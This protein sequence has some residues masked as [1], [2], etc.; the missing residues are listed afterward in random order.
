MTAVDDLKVGMFVAIVGDYEPKGW[1]EPEMSPFFSMCY[2]EPTKP[3][4]RA[5][6]QPLQIVAISLPFLA[7]TDGEKKYPIDVR[8]C[9]LQRLSPAYVR[10][11]M[12]QK[13]TKKA[14]NT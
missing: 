2:G 12:E 5:T 10:A 3:K 13:A 4:P 14:R 11:M 1:R 7:V 6:G 8:E 9:Q